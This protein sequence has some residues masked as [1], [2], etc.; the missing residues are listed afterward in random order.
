MHLDHDE[1]MHDH[2]HTHADGTTHSHAHHHH[3][4]LPDHEH[5]THA[6]LHSGEH[7]NCADCGYEHDTTM[8]ELKALLK[9]MVGHNTAHAEELKELAGKL[10]A[11]GET[12]A[13]GQIMQAVGD[14][15]KGNQRLSDVLTALNG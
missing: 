11:Q 13:C 3:E 4:D 10:Q 6:N 8:E 2:V 1:T 14:F 9:Y 12:S 15:E 5:H 7:F